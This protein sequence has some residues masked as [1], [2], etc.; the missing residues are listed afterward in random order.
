LAL[1]A[2]AGGDAG[3]GDAA[4]HC[5]TVVTRFEIAVTNVDKV[6]VLFVVDDSPSMIEEQA[7]LQRELP[8]LIETLFTGVRP[9]GFEF[10]PVKD[11][12][13]AVVSAD[14]G[15]GG[16]ED[17]LAGC[18][19]FGDDGAL[20]HTAQGEGCA[21]DYPPFLTYVERYPLAEPRSTVTPQSIAADVACLAP[22]G[23]NGCGYAQPLEAALLALER[24]A[25]EDAAFLRNDQ[26]TGLSLIS[27]ILVTDKDDCSAAD[28]S[29]FAELEEGSSVEARCAAAADQLHGLE[30][31]VERLRALRPGNESLVALGVIAGVPSDLLAEQRDVFDLSDSSAR[32]EF[33]TRVLL[34]PR[35]QTALR[36]DGTLAPACES[37]SAS[38]TPARRLVQLAARFGRSAVVHSICEEDWLPALGSLTETIAHS[39]G[40]VCLPRPLS[41]SP[42]G[43]TSCRLVWE[44]Q[45][46][47]LVHA[48][49]IG[50][51]S[52]VPDL[53]QLDDERPMTE[54]G[55]ERCIVRQLAVTGEPPAVEPGYGWY[56]DDFSDDVLKSCVASRRQMISFSPDVTLPSGVTVRMECVETRH[57]TPALGELVDAPEQPL[58]FDD[59]DPAREGDCD[60][61]LVDPSDAPAGVDDTLACHP[62]LRQCVVPCTN[63]SCPAG[64]LCRDGEPPWCEPTD[65]RVPG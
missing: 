61:L 14:L 3:D 53:L 57:V 32:A 51:C 2:C 65:C 47:D 43:L 18:T 52:E 55:G 28:P 12:H 30:R 48:G 41:R 11:G 19:A 5:V 44:L 56:Y 62:E 63:G 39:L 29:V 25:G 35:M 7:A 15:T 42:E 20:R 64:W 45:P 1:S 16:L 37:A 13:V 58:L 10:R 27:I 33:Y 49:S 50:A 34:D 40:A 36:D 38:A 9:D 17:A 23:A 46:P 4:P 31:Y 24:E 8:K 26:R 6:D 59:C 54:E 22:S 21:D 60:R